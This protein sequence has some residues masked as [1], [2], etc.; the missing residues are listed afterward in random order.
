M[1]IKAQSGSIDR[2]I[3]RIELEQAKK[4]APQLIPSKTLAST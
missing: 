4:P 2:T 1:S 3:G